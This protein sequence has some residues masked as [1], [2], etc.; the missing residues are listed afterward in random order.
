MC[1]DGC[2]KYAYTPFFGHKICAHILLFGIKSN[3]NK[4][5][6][7]SS[8]HLNM[9]PIE[10]QHWNQTRNLCS[11]C[12]ILGSSKFKFSKSWVAQF[13]LSGST[14]WLTL[15][16]L[17]QSVLVTFSTLYTLRLDRWMSLLRGPLHPTAQ[18]HLNRT[19]LIFTHSWIIQH[20]Y[21]RYFLLDS[22]VKWL[23][24]SDATV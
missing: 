2:W 17:S 23:W 8:F 22:M 11:L 5:A 7:L 20:Y 3:K 12:L 18:V 14:I 21:V 15:C 9:D 16:A 24:E 13:W 4:E 19:L 6:T 10:F 1:F